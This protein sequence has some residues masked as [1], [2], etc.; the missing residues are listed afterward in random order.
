MRHKSSS[1]RGNILRFKTIECGFPRSLWTEKTVEWRAP[2][3][4]EET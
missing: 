3:Q 2:W 1:P 4:L